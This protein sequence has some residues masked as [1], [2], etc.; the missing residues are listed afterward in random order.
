MTTV[1]IK[2]NDKGEYIG[3][4]CFGHAEYAKKGKP[5]ILCSAVSV[6]TINTLNCMEELFHEDFVV[7]Q[8]QDTGFLSCE[9]QGTLSLQSI[10]LMDAM[11]FGLQDL[12]NS[13]GEKFLLVKFEEV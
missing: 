12:S 1:T 8:N 11:V 4:H 3:F 9:F 5:D 6:L 13:Y 2:K 10:A 7:K